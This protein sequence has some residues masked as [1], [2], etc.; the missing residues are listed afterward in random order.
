MRLHARSVERT[1]PQRAQQILLHLAQSQA[2]VELT[3]DPASNQEGS[4]AKRRSR[5]VD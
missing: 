1:E 5:H 4:R 3:N 2:K